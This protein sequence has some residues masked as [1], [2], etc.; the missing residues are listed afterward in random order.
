MT[1]TIGGGTVVGPAGTLVIEDGVVAAIGGER[2]LDI[3]AAGGWICPGFIDVQINGSHGIDVTTQPGRIGEL[4]SILPRSGVT[5][6]LPTVITCAPAVRAA[7]FVAWAE[8][9][10]GPGAVPLGLHLEGPM[11]APA[12]R[13]AHPEQHLLDPDPAVVDGWSAAAGV[14]LATIAPEQ[15]GALDVIAILAGRGVVVSI[16]HTDCTSAEFAAGRAAGARYVTHLFNAMR[17]F[18]HRDPGPIGA[19]LADG[20]VVAGLICDGVHVDPVAVRMAWRALGPSRCNLVTDAVAALGA[21]GSRLGSDTLDV[22]G[23]E[24]RNAAGVLAGSVLTLDQAVRNLVAFT[25]CAV[26]DAVATVTS[27]PADLLGLTDRGRL[28]VG[29]RADVTVLD[30]DLRVVAT[31]VGGE[32]AWRS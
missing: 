30:A 19:A 12:R 9:S 28:A 27:T 20:S 16:G 32:V 11:L 14:A 2:P 8:R 25:G 1:L 24:V 4:A 22:A 5:A 29:A 13:G 15:P 6:F 23:G 26:P 10:A 3:D 18:D 7:A 21:V 17:P 31:I